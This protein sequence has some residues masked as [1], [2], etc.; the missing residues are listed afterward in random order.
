MTALLAALH[1]PIVA[2]LAVM[3]IP[4]IGAFAYYLLAWAFDR[5]EDGA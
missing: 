2:G 5:V 4:A 3:T 1:N